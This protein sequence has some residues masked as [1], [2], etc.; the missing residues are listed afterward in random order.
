MQFL[1]VSDDTVAKCAISPSNGY[2]RFCVGKFVVFDIQIA[3][4]IAK[5]QKMNS[6]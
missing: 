6:F 5:K 3:T 1:Q 4:L 2:V